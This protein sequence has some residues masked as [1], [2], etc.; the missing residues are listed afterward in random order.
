MVS[1]RVED[2]V[3]GGA[4]SLSR[5]EHEDEASEESKVPE[6]SDGENLSDIEVSEEDDDIDNKN[7]IYG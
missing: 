6:E 5:T 2:G 4:D 1:A 7:R 3:E